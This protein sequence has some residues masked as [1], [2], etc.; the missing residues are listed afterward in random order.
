[1]DMIFIRANRNIQHME[2]KF[3]KVVKEK[4]DAVLLGMVYDFD[5]WDVEMLEAVET[6]LANRSLMPD[7]IQ[8]RRQ[9]LAEKEHEILAR[10][11]EATLGGQIFGWLGCLGLF[12]LIIGYNYAYS[13]TRSRYTRKVYYKYDEPSRDNGSYIF[14]TACTAFTLY[15]LYKLVAFT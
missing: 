2:N 15:L 5:K 10:G 7:D 11:R 14:Y 9:N 3:L 1:M 8:E 4:T 6:E 12:G 13:K